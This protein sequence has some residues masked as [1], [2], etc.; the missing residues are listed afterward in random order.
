M[1]FPFALYFPQRSH[2]SQFITWANFLKFIFLVFLIFLLLSSKFRIYHC[3]VA[4]NI[5]FSKEIFVW[6]FTKLTKDI[7]ISPFFCIIPISIRKLTKIQK[8]W[9]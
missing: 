9:I 6:F 5:Y 8:K 3:I 7:W 1:T 2:L 4:S